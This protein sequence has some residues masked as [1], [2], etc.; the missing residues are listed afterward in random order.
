MYTES[1]NNFK[2][3]NVI[4]QFL[5][6]ALLVFILMWL[7]P[8]KGDLKKAKGTSG[9]TTTVESTDMS[10]LYDRIFNE[11]LLSMKES[12]QSY[13]TTERLPQKVGD[14]VQ[15]TLREML[16]KKIILPF[17]DKNGKQ[18]DLDESY[19]K[20]TKHENEFVM[21]VNLKC[22]SEENYLLTY[23]GC[24][25]YCS[26]TICEKKGYVGKVYKV[27]KTK[28]TK[29]YCKVV[30]GKYYDNYGNV[31]SKAAYEKACVKK[32]ETKYYCRIVNG[33]YYDNKGNKVSKEAYE[34]ACITKYFCKIVNGKYYNN[35][36]NVVSK[37]Q[38]EKDCSS[39]KYYCK[40]V[41]GKYYDN[42]GNV[43]S[44]EAYEKACVTR[45]FCKIVDGKYYNNL[46]RVVTKEQ[47]EKDC[48][49]PKYVYKYEY[50][51]DFAGTVIWSDWSAWSETYVAPS[52]TVEVQKKTTNYKKLVGYNVKTENDLTKPI[53]ETKK[54]LIGT[55]T[56]TA[57]TS[58]NVTSTVTGYTEKSLGTVKLTSAPTSTTTLRYEAVGTYAWYC[59]P[60]CT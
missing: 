16:D 39:K 41:N 53:V 6:I 54:V 2:I 3:R 11:N 38:Y 17:K 34:K 37:E 60:N 33:K 31:V 14:S 24:Y 48:F 44:K 45:Y 26:Q 47:Y 50:R 55:T 35:L 27:T 28:T 9:K 32:P 49:P 59:A 21:K 18:C 20:I 29:Y 1:R 40:I 8:T 58:Y 51:K 52:N 43:V 23:M 13:F 56:V 46:G 30:G 57:C 15:L 25:D 36:G 5:F 10:I 22:G 19:V 42:Y 4:L 7:F 12:A